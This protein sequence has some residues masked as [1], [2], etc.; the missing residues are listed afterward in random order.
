MSKLS[1]LASLVIACRL[2]GSASGQAQGQPTGAGQWDEARVKK[3]EQA[4]KAAA[5]QS[6]IN[7]KQQREKLEAVLTQQRLINEQQESKRRETADAYWKAKEAQNALEEA[8]A[9]S[10]MRLR[11]AERQRNSAAADVA[12]SELKNALRGSEIVRQ[13]TRPIAETV[14][15]WLSGAAPKSSDASQIAG[16]SPLEHHIVLGE[17][18]AYNQAVKINRALKD[19]NLER[20][21]TDIRPGQAIDTVTERMLGAV[22]RRWDGGPAAADKVR[23]AEIARICQKLADHNARVLDHNN[24]MPETPSFRTQAEI[25]AWNSNLP[26]HPY[27]V[28]RRVLQAEGDAI[29]RELRAAQ[30]R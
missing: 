16:Q 8:A 26:N 22:D 19:V 17:S 3:F 27:N 1:G 21:G 14:Y 2:L 7:D 11:E 4:V 18:Q 28:E 15:V 29:M 25:D 6:R 13:E 5:E 9:R 30:I 23:A 10:L 24:R 12:R 20:I